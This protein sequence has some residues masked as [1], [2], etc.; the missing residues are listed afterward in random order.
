M[1]RPSGLR[2]APLHW[3]VE[4]PEGLD[5]ADFLA[6][7]GKT[8]L[9][10]ISR[11]G[12]TATAWKPLTPS[13]IRPFMRT[14]RLSR[15]RRPALASTKT[16]LA[17]IREMG[18]GIVELTLHVGIGTFFLIKGAVVEG[19][20]MHRERYALSRAALEKVRETRKQGGRVIAV[21]TSA[22]RTL[23]TVCSANQDDAPLAGEHGPFHLSRLQVSGG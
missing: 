5:V 2:P 17:R 18:V 3:T 9:P 10:L 4:F 20:E 12:K 16:C 8:P 14:R 7:S 23:E 19:H 22:V 11:G 1:G 15:P 21:G 6:A 13:D